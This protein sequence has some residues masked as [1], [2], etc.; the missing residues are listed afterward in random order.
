[1]TDALVFPS[2]AN[3]KGNFKEAGAALYA[4]DLRSPEALEPVLNCLLAHNCVSFSSVAATMG[5]RDNIPLK[6]RKQ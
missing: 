1:M 3:G 6:R 4:R 2:S 5:H